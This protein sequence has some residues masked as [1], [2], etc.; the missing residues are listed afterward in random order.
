MRLSP[1]RITSIAAAGFLLATGCC[2]LLGWGTLY[3]LRSPD[4][5]AESRVE[6]RNCSADCDLRVVLQQ[7]WTTTELARLSD[8]TINFAHAAGRGAQVRCL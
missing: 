3:A 2:K 6:T 1:V 4:G 5:R 7:D 8:C